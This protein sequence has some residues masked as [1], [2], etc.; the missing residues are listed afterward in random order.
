MGILTS[1]AKSSEPLEEELLEYVGHKAFAD[2]C[3]RH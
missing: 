3:D 1:S 2:N